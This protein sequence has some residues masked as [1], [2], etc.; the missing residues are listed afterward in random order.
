VRDQQRLQ[1]LHNSNINVAVGLLAVH[2]GVQHMHTLSLR[3]LLCCH[4]AMA[5]KLPRTFHVL[6]LLGTLEQRMLGCND[7]AMFLASTVGS[8]DRR[9][10]HQPQPHVLL[11]M[12]FAAGFNGCE[13]CAVSL[14]LR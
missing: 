4:T 14:V 10:D 8:I 12:L 9:A 7:G 6:L 2:S 11:L 1:V 13:G 3:L 5:Y